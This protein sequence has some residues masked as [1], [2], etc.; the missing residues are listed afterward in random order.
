M[1]NGPGSATRRPQLEWEGPGDVGVAT[2]STSTWVHAPRQAR[3]QETFDRF[4]GSTMALLREKSFDDITVTDIVQGA[5]RT[6]GS[7]YARFDD[8]YAV[9]YEL[10]SR[11]YTHIGT[12]VHAFCDPVRWDGQPIRAFV[13]ESVRLNV[14]G[15]RH[16]TPLFRAALRA[17]ASDERFRD[18]RTDFLRYCADEQR[19][20]VLTRRD[21][22]STDSPGRASDHMFEIVVAVLD[23]ELLFGR[24]TTTSPHT[25]HELARELVDQALH[26]LGI[27]S[28]AVDA[29]SAVGHGY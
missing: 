5:D 1:A 10:V 16:S 25:D 12:I 20:F 13:E 24:L 17:A 7:F 19:A 2:A 28:P 22:L 18:R 4:L 21:E 3:S 9:L 6:V 27:P 23:Q 11:T 14:A 26:A 29:R 15:Y 8:K